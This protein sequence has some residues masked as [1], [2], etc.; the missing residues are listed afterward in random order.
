M[1]TTGPKTV[2]KQFKEA[3]DYQHPSYQKQWYLNTE[4]YPDH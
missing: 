1:P 4:N 2:S 3:I